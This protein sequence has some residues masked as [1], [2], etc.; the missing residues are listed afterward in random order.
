MQVYILVFVQGVSQI[1][2]FAFV[3]N[4]VNNEIMWVGNVLK[5]GN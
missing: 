4:I 3:V 5:S 2:L 1:I